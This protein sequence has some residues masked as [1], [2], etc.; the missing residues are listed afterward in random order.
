MLAVLMPAAR[1]AVAALVLAVPLLLTAAGAGA[2]QGVAQGA[3]QAA[4]EDGLG[5]VLQAA[6]ARFLAAAKSGDRV[7]LSQAISPESF[8]DAA[9]VI[10]AMGREF[11]AETVRSFADDAP[12]LSRARLIEVI[13]GKGKNEAALLYVRDVEPGAAGEAR[14]AFT[15]IRFVGR[16]GT[17]LYD[18]LID[19]EDAKLQPDG[20]ETRFDPMLL[21]SEFAVR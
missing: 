20:S 9:L 14:V 13:L 21:P 11:D 8:T 4:Q 1:T 6:Y 18:A 12:D 16:D 2:A 17:W 10:A 7:R 19:I 15:F 5:A 3:A